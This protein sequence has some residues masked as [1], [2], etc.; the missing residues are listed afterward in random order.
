MSTDNT[1][2]IAEILRRFDELPDD[3]VVPTAVTA[4]LHGISAQ[5][6]RKIYPSVQL[7]PNRKGQRV[8][9]IRAMSRNEKPTTAA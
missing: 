3:A 8:G 4:L 2:N 5:T 6:V 9:T 1:D 7:S